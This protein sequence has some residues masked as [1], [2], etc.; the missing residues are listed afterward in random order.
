MAVINKRERIVSFR[1]SEEEYQ[2]LQELT[3]KQGAHS[4]SEFAR[5]VAFLSQSRNSSVA[6]VKAQAQIHDLRDRFEEL[7]SQVE[8]LR[9]RI[10]SGLQVAA[11]A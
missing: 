6:E 2:L 5:T 11:S 7:V 3:A 1:V 10:E 4:V 8:D 9:R